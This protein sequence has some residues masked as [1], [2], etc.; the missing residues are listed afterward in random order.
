MAD[1]FAVKGLKDVLDVLSQL[2]QRIET[3]AIRSGLTAAAGVVRDE[4]RA[5][6]PKKSGLT[7]ASIRSGSP[8]KNQDSSFSISVSAKG[9]RHAFV[10]YFIEYGVRP[11]LIKVREEDKPTRT[12]RDGRTAPWSMKKI[13]RTYM[14]AQ[15]SLR[16]GD[17]FVGPVVSHPGF[18][19]RPF[20]RPALEM[21][22]QEAI[23]AFRDKIVAVVEKKTGF[24]IDAAIEGRAAA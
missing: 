2:G 8:R 20:L 21:K 14:T 19:A 13:N 1:A 11:H 6:L 3:Q 12:L 9:T 22:A 7:A 15:G 10:A 17:Q 24:D 23:A 16:I 5:R 4:A 18:A